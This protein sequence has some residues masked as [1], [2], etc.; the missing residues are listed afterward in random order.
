MTKGTKNLCATVT[1]SGKTCDQKTYQN[2]F[3][4]ST[5]SV[6]E[7]SVKWRLQSF[8][9]HKPSDPPRSFSKT[10]GTDLEGHGLSAHVRSSGQFLIIQRIQNF[11]L[12]VMKIMIRFE[13]QFSLE[14]TFQIDQ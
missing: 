7:N 2:T 8:R 5:G 11:E 1:P 14:P 12:F 3:R 13:S 10:T 9:L 6:T 4:G